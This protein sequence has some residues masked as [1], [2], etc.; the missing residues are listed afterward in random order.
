MP[1]FYRLYHPA[2]RSA[3]GAQ[4]LTLSHVLD[5]EGGTVFRMWSGG[6]SASHLWPQPS[7]LSPISRASSLALTWCRGAVS[8]R[9][10]LLGTPK[11]MVCKSPQVS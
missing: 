11:G 5:P 7:T 1:L 10:T 8:G 3:V 2:N 4:A 9:D 6:I